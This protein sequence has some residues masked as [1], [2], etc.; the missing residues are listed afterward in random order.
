MLSVTKAT[1]GQSR[2]FHRE[3]FPLGGTTTARLAMSALAPKRKRTATCSAKLARRDKLVLENLALVKSIAIRIH[4]TLPVHLETDD[5]VNAGVIGLMDAAT[6]FDPKKQ[7]CFGSYA[8]H[9]I[10]G[11]ILDSLRQLDWASR[12]LR[13]R[14]K[15]AEAAI[16]DLT[17]ELHRAPSEAEIA[18]RL[19]ID[20]QKWR[21]MSVD[22]RNTGLISASSRATD[23]EDLP[24][25]DYAGAPDVQPDNMCAQSQLKSA[26]DVAMTV[27]PNRYQQV[28]H[29][30]YRADMTMKEI[31]TV[32]GI[33]ESRV[34]QIHKAA[35]E[36]M[37]VA[38]MGAGIHS[39][40][41]F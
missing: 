31:G 13:R 32:L 4:E 27:L 2:G 5:L 30:Y 20:V 17:A 37:H 1:I 38:L 10:K 6:K 39:S 3:E 12:D 14:H 26:L 28:V 21:Q 8:K 18:T 24:E 33:N 16:R 40:T 22:L 11:A 9:R 35:L 41:A 34:S 19:G 29:M 36:K 25:P 15:Q 7:V 23:H